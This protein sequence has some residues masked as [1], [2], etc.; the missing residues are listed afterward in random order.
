M[1]AVRIYVQSRI[2]AIG[3][4]LALHYP[5]QRNAPEHESEGSHMAQGR[6]LPGQTLCP[7]KLALFMAVL[8]IASGFV[9]RRQRSPRNPQVPRPQSARG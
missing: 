1:H 9:Q 5:G 3:D 4:Q 2:R 8:L 7:I 6:G